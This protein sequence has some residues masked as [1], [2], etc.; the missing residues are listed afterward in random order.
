MSRVFSLATVYRMVT[1][2]LLRQFFEHLEN[3]CWGM[4]WEQRP[5][6]HVESIEQCMGYLDTKQRLRAEQVLRQVF[7]LACPTG[8]M[9]IREAAKQSPRGGFPKG[10]PENANLYCQALWCWLHLRRVFDQALVYHEV[11]QTTWWRKR[12]DLPK[13]DPGTDTDTLEMLSS[14]VSD[15]LSR[16]DGRGRRC[17]VEH[18]RRE[19]GT[20]YFLCYP[21]DYLRSVLTHT[22]SG[23]LV[24]RTIRPTFEIIFAYRQAEGT[25]ELHAKVSTALKLELEEAF[26]RIVL[27]EYLGP[28]V[29]QRIYELDR[30]KE[31]G[32]ALQTDP[33][34]DCH[35]Q[36]RRLR[37]L[38]PDRSHVVL[39]PNSP[40]GGNASEMIESYLNDR[41]ASPENVK[42]CQATFRFHFRSTTRRERGTMTFD[43]AAPNTCNLRSQRPERV[44]IAQKH[45]KLWRIAR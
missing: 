15:L 12:D 18:C 35:V 6:R 19:N 29:P 14:E 30:L 13:V 20:D 21:D 32:F 1:N 34:D 28:P 41:K 24:S 33:A 43:I 3:P 31:P 39:E 45:L 23:R 16:D 36:L 7:E 37:L 2:D 4:I 27:S 42:I 26:S 9:A 5:R 22:L 10:W 40:T 38:L 17:T 8:S 44:E 25:L 11:E